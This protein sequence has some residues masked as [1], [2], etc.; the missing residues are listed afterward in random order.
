SVINKYG[1]WDQVRV[2]CGREWYLML[3]INLMFA[4][5]R[6][7]TTK[8]PHLRSSSKLNHTMERIW[9]EVNS[10]VN[11]YHAGFN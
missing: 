5:L 9:V 6:T 11:S 10:Q 2:D 3:F 1:L 7:S 4:H 8:Q